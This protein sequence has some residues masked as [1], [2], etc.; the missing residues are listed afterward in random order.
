MLNGNMRLVVALKVKDTY[1]NIDDVAWYY[2]NIPSKLES[3]PYGTQPVGTKAPSELGIYDMSGNVWE[4]CSDCDIFSY[5]STAEKNPAIPAFCNSRVVRGSA[6]DCNWGG[7]LVSY[8]SA[9]AYNHR[10]YAFG[11]RLACSVE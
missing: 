1:N 2:F 9:A 7:L 4:W 6:W 5:P 3:N 10:N 8:R 11:F